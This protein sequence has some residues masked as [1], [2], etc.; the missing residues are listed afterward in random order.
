MNKN[1]YYIDMVPPQGEF[2]IAT[3]PASPPFNMSVM[4]SSLV[5]ILATDSADHPGVFETILAHCLT[6]WLVTFIVMM[7]PKARSGL[8]RLIRTGMLTRASWPCMTF[9]VLPVMT[10]AY[11][12]ILGAHIR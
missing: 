4:R 11:M 6:V 3:T 10:A 5:H 1:W 2:S 8:G 7:L 9:Y 12:T